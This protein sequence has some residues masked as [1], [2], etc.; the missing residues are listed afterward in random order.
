MLSKNGFIRTENHS[1]TP[2]EYQTIVWD[3]ISSHFEAKNLVHLQIASFNEFIERSIQQIILDT[4]PIE[5]Q[6][7]VQHRTAG[8]EIAVSYLMLRSHF[9]VT[10]N[11]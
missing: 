9:G 2:R 11:L 1:I 4:P 3:I 6:G 7:E 8:Q 10:F 5:L